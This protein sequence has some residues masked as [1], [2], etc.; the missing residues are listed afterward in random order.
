MFTTAML[1]VRPSTLADLG[2]DLGADFGV[3]RAV[4]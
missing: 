2:T 1:R 3:F 4:W